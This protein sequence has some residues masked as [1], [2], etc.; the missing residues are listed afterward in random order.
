M[1][2]DIPQARR[3]R[4]IR[5]A[6]K[7]GATKAEIKARIDQSMQSRGELRPNQIRRKKTRRAIML[8]KASLGPARFM[9]MLNLNAVM[10][11]EL[12]KAILAVVNPFDFH[13]RPGPVGGSTVASAL[14]PSLRTFT[15]KGNSSS[16]AFP[17]AFAIGIR[18]TMGSNGTIND[19]QISI[20]DPTKDFPIDDPTVYPSDVGNWVNDLDGR[21]P[22][23]DDNTPLL[24]MD[25]TSIEVTGSSA[26]AAITKPWGD[27]PTFESN[28]GGD[29]RIRYQ[30]TNSRFYLNPGVYRISGRISG[31]GLGNIN[32]TNGSG[33]T[34][35]ITQATNTGGTNALCNSLTDLVVSDAALAGGTNYVEI[36]L[37][38]RS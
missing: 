3:A 14:Y 29:T 24:L 25:N 35:T 7:E 18:P 15:I 26:G 30:T 22:R 12:L 31:T 5:K 23:V 37:T 36:T 21:D 16:T 34:G 38:S 33:V 8:H 11:D 9:H 20:W 2:Q 17:G 27:A 1:T 4:I 32:I 10:K 28:E 13:C 6:K 19:Y